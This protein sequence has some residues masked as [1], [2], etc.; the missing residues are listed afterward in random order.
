VSGLITRDLGL[1]RP[2]PEI[3]AEMQRFTAER[4]GET[5]DEIW[6]VEH[7]PIFTLGLN[8]DPSHLLAPGEIPVLKIDRGGQVTYHGPGQLVTYVLLDLRRAQMSV[9]RLV[10][11]LE[12]AV[13][14]TVADYG[15][16]AHCRRDAPGVYVEDKKLAAIGLRVRRHC[17]Y[18]GIAVNVDMDLSPFER[19]NP[20]GFEDLEATQLSALCS[21]HELAR[22]REDLEPQ[23]RDRLKA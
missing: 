21:V 6:F 19:I 18:H 5:P 10:E 15:V 16:D 20:C 4:S 11:T 17:S 9:R 23:L 3:W 22:L 14:D 13:I 2:L 7:A 12:A 1:S 8:A